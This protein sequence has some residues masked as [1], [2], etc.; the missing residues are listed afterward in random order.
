MRKRIVEAVFLSVL[1]YGDV[2]YGQAASS[3]L[4]PLE[5]VDHSALRFIT[6]DT[7]VMG[8]T[9]AYYIKKLAC[10]LYH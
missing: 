10:L 9:I 8:H 3:T 2:I 5:A 7:V 1:D 6:G 4:K